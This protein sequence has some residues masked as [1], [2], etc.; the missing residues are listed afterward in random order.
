MENYGDL[1]MTGKLLKPD[2]L[3]EHKRQMQRFNSRL[4][5]GEI[6]NPEEIVR[7]QQ[8]T[9]GCGADGCCF[10]S[11]TRKDKDAQKKA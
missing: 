3:I 1:F 2:D 7:I 9:C 8:V 11:V 6:E 5:R 4:K 10:I